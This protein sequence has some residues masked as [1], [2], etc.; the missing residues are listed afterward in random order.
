M[1]LERGAIKQNRSLRP[2]EMRQIRGALGALNWLAGS[3]RPDLAAAVSI[4]PAEL[5]TAT[6]KLVAE[7]NAVLKQAQEV[8]LSL[9]FWPIDPKDRRLVVFGDS[10]CDTNG[11][12]RNQNGFI[13]GVTTP[14]LQAGHAAPVSVLAWRSRKQ[15]RKSG[16]PQACETFAASWAVKEAAWFQALLNSITYSVHDLESPGLGPRHGGRP[17][18]IKSDDPT[19]RNPQ[20]MLVTDSKGV[21]DTV[22]SELAGD[23]KLSALEVPIIKGIL[24]R[25]QGVVRWVPHNF[26]PADA[27]TKIRGAHLAPMLRLC[28]SGVYQLTEEAEHLKIRAQEKTELGYNKRFTEKKVNAAVHQ[29]EC[30]PG[31]L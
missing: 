23:D 1:S 29:R 24:Q 3:G 18:I 9:K 6:T 26:N 19:W 7:V 12:G 30:V 31:A 17:V 27:L 15:P 13:L 22:N 14:A 2:E 5:P 21:Y 8:T 28:S 25:T 16:S 11:K 4:L 10:S 20:M